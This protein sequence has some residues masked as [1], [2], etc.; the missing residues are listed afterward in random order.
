[1]KQGEPFGTM[2]TEENQYR[3]LVGSITDHAIYMLDPAGHVKSWNPGAGRLKGYEAEEIVGR[4]FSQFYIPEDAA[5]G[6]PQRALDTA[7]RE[8]RFENQGWRIRKDG[9][10]FLA[11]VVVD[12]VRAP[13]GVLIGF[14][15]ITRDVTEWEQNQQALRDARE[16]LFQSHKMEAVGQLTGGIAHDFNNLMTGIGGCLEIIN[17]RLK[18]GR[19]AELDR[20]I[21]AAQTAINR[22]ATLTHRLLAFSR[23]QTL[24]PKAIDVNRLVGGMEELIR[25]TVGPAVTVAV[26]GANGLWNT[27]VDP[28]QLESALLNL[29]INARDAM[30]GGGRLTVET[31]NRLFDDRTA[32]SHDML[33]GQ[34]ISLSVSD[35]GTGMTPDVVRRAF[36]PFFTT[37]PAGHG[38]GLG[39]SMI[40]GFAQQSNGQAR[41]YSEIG[42]GSTV[43]IYLPRHSG[44]AD[45]EE[46]ATEADETSRAL[47]GETVLVVDDDMTVRM[48]ISEVLA[49]M[50]YATIEVTEAAAGLKVLKSDTHIDLLVSDIG[51]PGA[52]NGTQMV[53]EA[54]KSRPFLK[55][56]FITGFA[57]NAAIANGVLEPGTKVLTKPFALKRLALRIR[58]MISDE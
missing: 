47:P 7:A 13:D 54:R 35:N 27:L 40:S 9:T 52:V 22:A 34:Y 28:N 56:L 30:P 57:E 8:G 4:H 1:M 20:Y 16:A 19:I 36:D 17:L 24:S 41:I 29:C 42:Q 51:L 58:E 6:E 21:D 5:A 12:P 53:E 23:Q 44:E 45:P 31:A 55:V 33:P 49:D 10:R 46:V 2:L 50:G 15:K 3:L 26:V 37:K 43:T 39:L 11:N 14:A 48:L 38:T 25:R 32:T 18:Q